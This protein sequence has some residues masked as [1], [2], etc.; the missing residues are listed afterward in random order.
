MG[1]VVVITGAGS[2]LGRAMA[3]RLAREGHQL[4]LLG[5]S[6]AKVEAVAE[7]IGGG[8]FALSCDVG[9]VESV[10]SAFAAIAER[11]PRIDV[12][13]NNAAVYEPFMIDEGSDEQIAQA[14]DTNLAGT[15]HVTRA[16]L[17][18]MGEG[19][20]VINISTRT[21]A[22]PAVMLALYQTSKA[23]LERF[24]KTLREE[25]AE[26]GIRVSMLRAAGM[27]EEGMTMN[28]SPEVFARFR[29]E[30]AKRKI[31]YNAVSQ[32]ASVADMLPWL[33]DLPADV[34]VTE[35]MLEAR[36]T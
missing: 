29:E 14:L 26:R 23:G 36:A 9:A 13:I 32:F 19:S 24:T 11:E 6:L 7:E 25:V 33:I 27:M 30:R 34:A 35:L 18:Q 8:A 3:R 4:V 5:R 28:M 2:G 17:A 12:L 21:V 15:I 10:R 31:G 16:A 1:K 22:E 20:H